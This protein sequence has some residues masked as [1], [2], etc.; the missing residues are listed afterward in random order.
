[1]KYVGPV[2]VFSRHKEWHR[3]STH[4]AAQQATVGQLQLKISPSPE[5]QEVIHSFFDHINRIFPIGVYHICCLYDLLWNKHSVQPSH[6]VDEAYFFEAIVTA[7]M[8][9]FSLKPANISVVSVTYEAP[10]LRMCYYMLLCV[11]H[12]LH[13]Q[14]S[15]AKRYY[16]MARACT[17]QAIKTPSQH[18]ISALLVMT[19]FARYI[20]RDVDQAR[21]HA[22]LA[23]SL[24]GTIPLLADKVC[25]KCSCLLKTIFHI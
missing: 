4:V 9:G 21:V 13:G 18:L 10:G 25:M 7:Q 8:E 14:H 23:K 6:S 11:G 19:I 24:A 16:Y 5:E 20:F 17:A 3:V 12:E 2:Q 22:E 15:T 1:M